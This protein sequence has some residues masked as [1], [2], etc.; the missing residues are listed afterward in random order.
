[1]LKIAHR[2]ASGHALENTKE[3]FEKAIYLDTEIIEF[4]VR[5]TKDKKI[6]VFHDDR[7]ER[8][9]NGKGK[10]KN[11]TLKQ[12]K[13]ITH[14]N[15]DFILTLT[16]ALKILKNKCGCKIDIKEKGIEDKVNKAIKRSAMEKQTIITTE[17]F[18]V[19]RK[20]RKIN[21]RLKISLGFKENFPAEKM[22]S[23][24]KRA[25]VDIIG[26]HFSSVNKE[27]VGEAH[28][29]GLLVDVWGVNTE[30]EIDQLKSIGVDAITTDYPEKI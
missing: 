11:L 18:S 6:V 10:I 20:I 9:T 7:L 15:G 28:K 19:A 13:T 5:E 14:K 23:L 12:L 3:A 16:E 22:I 29:N 21:P 26:P 24:A 2:G 4:D 17:Y 25:G 1:M 27:L 30:E 8:T